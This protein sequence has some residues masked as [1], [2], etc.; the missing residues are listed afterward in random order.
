[1]PCRARGGAP[2]SH[3][4]VDCF[5]VSSAELS[6]S[7]IHDAIERA[8][9]RKKAAFTPSLGVRRASRPTDGRNRDPCA[10][11]TN[12]NASPMRGSVACDG[13]SHRGPE[14]GRDRSPADC[15]IQSGRPGDEIR[16]WDKLVSV[17]S[18]GSS[19]ADVGSLTAV[20]RLTP[21]PSKTADVVKSLANRGALTH[22]DPA[23]SSWRAA[24]A[25]SSAT[26]PSIHFRVSEHTAP[27][28]SRPG[29]DQCGSTMLQGYSRGARALASRSTSTVTKG[30]SGDVV[31]NT[32]P[33]GATTIPAPA[34]AT[35]PWRPARFDDAT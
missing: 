23:R 3:S 19:C 31:A 16:D 9:P 22:R 13:T 4:P 1:M 17:R 27:T 30:Q 32:R 2:S 11:S 21:P 33:S 12:G 20:T 26:S 7:R 24:A 25:P 6:L 28:V 8:W 14:H 34:N 18:M 5:S 29:S 35:L 15:A 10:D